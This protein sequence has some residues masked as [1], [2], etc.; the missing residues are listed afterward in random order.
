VAADDV[1]GRFTTLCPT[2]SSPPAIIPTSLIPPRLFFMAAEWNQFPEK[3]VEWS[4]NKHRHRGA[5]SLLHPVLSQNKM[6]PNFRHKILLQA[7]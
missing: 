6:G 7:P 1:A 3:L 5:A 2:L 4:V